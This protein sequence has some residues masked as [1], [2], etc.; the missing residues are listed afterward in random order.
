MRKAGGRWEEV[1]AR[2]SSDCRAG[3]EGHFVILL[4]K[5]SCLNALSPQA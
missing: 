4:P 2:E 1:G 5:P 3:A